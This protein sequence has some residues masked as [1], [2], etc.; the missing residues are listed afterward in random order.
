MIMK[1][2]IETLLIAILAI[3]V[4]AANKTLATPQLQFDKSKG[5]T[6]TMTMPDGSIVQYTAYEGMFFVTNVE[7]SVYQTIN[8]YV[9]DGVTQQT[10]IFLRT[11][12]GG[13]MASK[14]G[15]PQAGDATGRA[16]KEGYVVAIPGSRGRNSTVIAT[17]ADKK[18]GIKKGQTI[19]TGRA[20]AAILDLKAAIRYLRHFDKEMLGDAEKII[21]D[22]T[23]AGGAMSALM[24]ATGNNP[25]YE[26]LL[27]AM[28]AAD[29][30]DDVFASVCFCPI[31][32]L[33]HADMAYEWLFNGTD[34]RQ[35]GDPDVLAVSNEL[36]AQFP[37]YINSLNLRTPDGTPLTADNYLDFIKQELI[38]S[39]QLAKNAGADI[40][41]SIGFKF[42]T[43][44]G[45][46]APP[47]N[48]GM[49]GD[50][51]KPQGQMPPGMMR[52]GGK[53]AGEYITDLDMQQYLNYVVTTQ[54]LKT[55]PAFDT[56]GVCSQNASGENEEFGDATGT[57]VNYT[58][59]GAQKTGSALTDGIRQNVRLLNPMNFIGDHET[60]VAPHWYIRHGARD[61]DTSFPIPLS[62]ALKLQ[63]AGKDVDYL[64]PWNRPHSGDYALDE[65]FTWI[66]KITSP[67]S[68]NAQVVIDNIM[69][70]TSIR[71]YTDEPISPKDV[72]TLLRAGMA[73]PTAV[74]AQPWHFV[75]ITDKAKLTELAATNR[76]GRM[77]EEAALA[78]VVCG[79]MDKAMQGKGQAYWIQDCSAATENILLAAHGLGL[80]A[81]WTGLYP[82]DERVTAVAAVLK[83][84]EN[85]VP[86]CTIVIGHPAESPTPKDKW[87]PE[88]ISYNEYVE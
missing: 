38:R 12:V 59:Y 68:A 46:G 41:D 37:A 21:T 54:P 35:Q 42:N 1:R 48:G 80:G 26:P 76:H 69:T 71:R 78:I 36:K 30:R 82:M 70:R 44:S 28:G 56:K 87:K 88:N 52:G 13:Y 31:T 79:D 74:N 34:S 85:L 63:N 73:A 75:A 20:P 65:L 8:I 18:A 83:L 27:Q 77:I 40:S 6:R 33:D 15:Q 49:T 11:Y 10:P 55:A 67:A 19:Y 5:E 86:L 24:G 53:K 2:I 22:G 14:A 61:R 51:Q 3:S 66:R 17:K 47:I 25:A 81:V 16:L 50:K 39:A 60:D 72:E 23:S 57:S 84:P 64:L 43:E 45:F 29:E 32:D 7:D 9:P 58:D 4:M 62:L